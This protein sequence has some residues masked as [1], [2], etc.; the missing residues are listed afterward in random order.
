MKTKNIYTKPE[1]SVVL[2]RGEALLIPN[3]LQQPHGD[4]VV[5]GYTNPII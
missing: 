5:D 2:L 1:T 3:S 4:T